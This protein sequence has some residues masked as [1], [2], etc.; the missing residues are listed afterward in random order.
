LTPQ[1]TLY[2]VDASLSNGGP[3]MKDRLWFFYNTRYTASGTT[4]PG[5][6]YNLNAGDP[7][8]WTYFADT[9]RPA[10]NT[11]DGAFNPTLRLTAQATPKNK[12]NL[13]WDPGSFRLSDRPQIGGITGPTAGAPETAT[14]SGGTGFHQG[15]YAR[16]E[17]AR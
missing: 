15:G 16:M 11:S 13:Y 8:K 12:L 4:L 3:I 17:T 6:F 2:L 7:T 5:M 1:D 10:K 14:V 9:T